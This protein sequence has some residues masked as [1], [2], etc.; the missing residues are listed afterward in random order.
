M[1]LK[2]VIE[3]TV[4][5]VATL[6]DCNMDQLQ[7]LQLLGQSTDRNLAVAFARQSRAAI[8]NLI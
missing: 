3:D 6:Q 7:P 1:D 2:L 4:D 5:N 8:F